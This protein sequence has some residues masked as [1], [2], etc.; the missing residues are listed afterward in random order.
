M[1]ALMVFESMF[2]N[3]KV[4]AD[5]VAEGLATR[6]RVTAVEVGVAPAAIEDDVDLVV[7]G[8]PTHAFGMSRP[9]TRQDAARQAER[10][11]V[12]AGSGLR[13]WLETVRGG[14]PRVAAAGVR[15]ADRQAEAAGIG[16]A[17][18]RTAAAAARLPHRRP[19]CEL[20][21]HWDAGAACGWRAGA[22]PSLGGGAGSTG[23]Q[24][25]TGSTNPVRPLRPGPHMPWAHWRRSGT[26]PG[27]GIMQET[28]LSTATTPS[29][30]RTRST[31][32]SRSRRP[33]AWPSRRTTPP[34]T[35]T[36]TSTLTAT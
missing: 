7:V 31:S 36:P 27:S 1:R 25:A 23:R 14:S 2:G 17:R 33:R 34:S 5:A 24:G 10:P 22:R 21:R 6:M 18:S 13:D 19:A 15:H 32:A 11:L 26:T 4:I 30:S 35:R 16:R 29:T 28:W 3:T 9:G 8:G 12:S 20:L